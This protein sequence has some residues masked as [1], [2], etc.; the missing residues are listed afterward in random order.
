MIWQQAPQ[1][2]VKQM[3][4]AITVY[5]GISG[6]EAADVLVEQRY[7]RT[8]RAFFD[9]SRFGAG[10]VF[11]H[12]IYSVSDFELAAQYA[13]YHAVRE[14]D[15]G[16]V[17]TQTLTFHRPLTLDDHYT[18][19]HLRSDVLRWRLGAEK[20]VE[21][22]GQADVQSICLANSIRRYV[23]HLGFDGIIILLPSGSYYYISYFPDSQISHIHMNFQFSLEDA[24]QYSFHELKGVQ[25]TT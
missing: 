7:F 6:R 13:F 22:E 19:R 1:Q 18:E 14:N 25:Q 3:S 9:D 10:A 5:R 12:G 20:L 8:E 17:L 24:L 11:G 2:E 21:L 23:L 4:D 15:D 16:A